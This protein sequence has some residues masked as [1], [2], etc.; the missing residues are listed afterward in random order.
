MSMSARLPVRANTNQRL[1]KSGRLL[2]PEG[3]GCPSVCG[4][5]ACSLTSASSGD[6]CILDQASR[7]NPSWSVIASI[8]TRLDGSTLCFSLLKTPVSKSLS[9]SGLSRTDDGLCPIS[10]LQLAKNARNIVA[11]RLRIDH[12]LLSDLAIAASLGYQ[13]ENFPFPLGQIRKGQGRDGLPW[14]GKELHQALGH[15]RTEDSFPFAHRA[16]GSEHLDF[17]GLFQ[18]IATRS[19]PQ[20]GEEGIVLLNKGDH[21][22]ATVRVR[23]QDATCRLDATDAWHPQIHD[24][25]IR[26]Q[27]GRQRH[28]LLS[29]GRFAHHLQIFCRLQQGTHPAAY[30]RMVISNQNAQNGHSLFPF[31]DPPQVLSKGRRARTSVPPAGA[32]TISQVPPS[33][34]ARSRM[35]SSPTPAR[36][37]VCTPLP[38]SVIST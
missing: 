10:H 34:A 31:L 8:T 12:Q 37:A 25:H 32:G 30:Q 27:G 38:S 11:H 5:K 23:L 18:D 15:A 36:E 29:A 9:Q 35:E 26:L 4:G 1:P 28:H 24:D 2:R 16:D 20:R 7:F 21:E 6:I 19:R 13:D 22:N 3:C 17:T 14:D 33:S